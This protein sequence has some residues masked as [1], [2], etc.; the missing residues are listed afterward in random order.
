MGW[1]AE[2]TAGWRADEYG[3]VFDDFR[4]GAEWVAGV[5]DARHVKSV[6]DGA[7]GVSGSDAR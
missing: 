2:G 3:G 7:V 4:F 1:V 6:G 5:G